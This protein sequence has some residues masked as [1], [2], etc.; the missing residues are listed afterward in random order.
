MSNAVQDKIKDILSQLRD[1]MHHA[2]QDA[3]A[4]TSALLSALELGHYSFDREAWYAL[5]SSGKEGAM[6]G[7][8]LLRARTNDN[9]PINPDSA[10]KA[11]GLMGAY[12]IF[13]ALITLTAVDQAVRNQELPISINISSRN[14]SDPDALMRLHTMLQECFGDQ[15]SPAQITFEFL[16]D[17]QVD[18]PAHTAL[19]ALRAYGYKFAI[20]DQSHEDWDM[21]RPVSLGPYVDYIKIDGKTLC[22]F[23]NGVLNRADFKGFIDRLAASAPNAE[24]LCEWV[25]SPE[26]A[27]DLAE[28]FPAIHFVQGRELRESQESFKDRI[29]TART[30]NLNRFNIA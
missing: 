17:D 29:A 15:V 19:T 23:R 2:D 9:T 7:E 20:D 3:Q 16:E 18:Q 11:I 10:G 30:Q 1:V 26:E 21:Q 28:I 5:E 27:E 8:F 24:F 4:Q 22:A 6:R 14:A 13:D 12:A 25:K